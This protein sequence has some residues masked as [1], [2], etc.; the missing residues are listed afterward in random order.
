MADQQDFYLSCCFAQNPGLPIPMKQI[1]AELLL[2]FTVFL[3]GS[4]YLF[5]KQG[6]ETFAPFNLIALRF[7]I[8]FLIA[9]LIFREIFSGLRFRTVW[10]AAMLGFMIFCAFAFLLCGLKGEST[11][12]AGFLIG[13]TVVIVPI[14]QAVFFSRI[15]GS[16]SSSGSFLPL[17][18]SFSSRPVRRL[19]STSAPSCASL[20]LFSAHGRSSLPPGT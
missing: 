12:G 11:T 13:T 5:M 3:W 20:P 19:F 6:M 4:S 7:G 18:G 17:P 16:R 8:A 9:A 14:L 1:T 15:P 2:V 10:C